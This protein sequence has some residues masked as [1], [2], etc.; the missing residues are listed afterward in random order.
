MQ[1]IGG[2]ARLLA[3]GLNGESPS[4]PLADKTRIE[5]LNSN[6]HSELEGSSSTVFDVRRGHIDPPVP[7]RFCSGILS[8]IHTPEG[9]LR[10]HQ[11]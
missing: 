2:L 8:Y 1:L 10:V 9:A 4:F 7:F 3:L 6:D 11:G 5:G